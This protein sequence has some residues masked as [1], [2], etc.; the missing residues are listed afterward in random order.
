MAEAEAKTVTLEEYTNFTD[1][2]KAAMPKSRRNK[3][4]K[5][6]MTKKKKAR[7]HVG[8]GTDHNTI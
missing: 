3:M 5:L 8:E 1:E 4:E 2:E 7:S 6:I